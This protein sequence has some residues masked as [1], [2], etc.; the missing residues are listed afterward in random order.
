MVAVSF[1]FAVDSGA[2]LGKCPGLIFS[3][4]SVQSVVSVPD[5]NLARLLT[6]QCVV[7]LNP[8]EARR[9]GGLMKGKEDESFSRN[10]PADFDLRPID[11][12]GMDGALFTKTAVRRYRSGR[13]KAFFEDDP[14]QCLVSF[15]EEGDFYVASVTEISRG[16]FVIG[17]ECV[18]NP[19]EEVWYHSFDGRCSYRRADEEHGT[20]YPSL[21]NMVDAVR[22]R[23]D[24][25]SA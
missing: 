10:A 25:G 22:K 24:D 14:E 4:G 12:I 20:M 5:K 23:P 8:Q 19:A 21:R 6:H 9:N 15:F 16:E 7:S 3:T 17:F 11:A 13:R 1:T 2:C 18:S